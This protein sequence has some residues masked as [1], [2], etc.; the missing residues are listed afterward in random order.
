M[1]CTGP[2]PRHRGVLPAGPDV[3]PRVRRAL[4]ASSLHDGQ[5]RSGGGNALEGETN[6][7]SPRPAPDAAHAASGTPEKG[8]EPDKLYPFVSEY[9]SGSDALVQVPCVSETPLIRHAL[10][11]EYIPGIGTLDPTTRGSPKLR[12]CSSFRKHLM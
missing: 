7:L 5:L 4:H 11:R 6:P 1:N 3:R 9:A 12:M 8:S 2:D 10:R